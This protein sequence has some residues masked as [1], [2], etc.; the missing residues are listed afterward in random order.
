MVN[1]ST[2]KGFFSKPS[3]SGVGTQVRDRWKAAGFLG[4]IA[5]CFTPL[6][7]ILGEQASE[8]MVDTLMPCLVPVAMLCC[9]LFVALSMFMVMR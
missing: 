6:G 1:A 4:A 5:A 7:G 9:S 2:K 8:N 3:S